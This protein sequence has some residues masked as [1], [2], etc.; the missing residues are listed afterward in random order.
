V[1]PSVMV[2]PAGRTS[3]LES[4]ALNQGLEPTFAEVLVNDTRLGQGDEL[5][6][7][8]ATVAIDP[9]APADPDGNL[10][11]V[12]PGLFVVTGLDGLGSCSF[13]LSAGSVSKDVTVTI[14]ADGIEFVNPPASILF[15]G[16]AQLEVRLV[17]LE[18]T[19]VTPFDATDVTW[20]SDDETVLTVDETG[21]I[22][23]VGPGTATITACWSGTDGTGTSGLGVE[24]CAEAAIEVIVG[25]PDLTSLSPASGAFQDE[26]TI[27]GTGFVS[28]HQLYIDGFDYS[29][30]IESLTGSA[31]TFQWPNVG[32]GDHTVEVGIPG[33]VSNTLTFTQTSDAEAN[34]PENDSDV[35]T[36]ATMDAGGVYVG[37]FGTVPGDI[38]DWIIV[39]V[40]ADGGYAPVLYWNSG[41]DLDL[42]VYDDVGENLCVSYYSQ[43]EDECGTLELTA[44]TY[45]VLVEDYTA[46][47]GSP[48]L[49]SYALRFDPVEE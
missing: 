44:G 23:G 39:T 46:L 14:V 45:Y 3:K 19:T 47:I 13:T 18:G 8:C 28:V 42:L 29:Y 30:L 6:V 49:A 17:S 1:N 12:P 2:V 32:N 7:G 40:P 4:R 16:T 22:T 27:N 35:T 9:D 34:E 25:V 31:I 5:N 11:Y 24:R 10:V 26:V 20:S 48:A 33:S 38:D 41:Q 21:F 36:T 37:G 15:A 43:P